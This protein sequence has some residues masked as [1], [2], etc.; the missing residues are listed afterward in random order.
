[1][2]VY[3]GVGVNLLAAL[4]G[5][6]VSVVSRRLWRQFRFRG[7]REFWAPFSGRRCSFVIGH[8]RSEVLLTADV[9]A[10]LLSGFSPTSTDLTNFLERMARHL[11][12][13]ENSGLIGLGDLEAIM[14]I[15]ARLADAGL[16]GVLSVIASDGS[17]RQTDTNLVLIGGGD[18][19]LR[20]KGLL[21]HLHCTYRMVVS[22][23][24]NAIWDSHLDD[25]YGIREIAHAETKT[26][27]RVDHGII[28]RAIAHGS[29]GQGRHVLILA[30]AQ[31][32]GTLA[33]ARAAFDN[34]DQLSS[35]SENHP[36]GFECVVKCVRQFNDEGQL[37][38]ESVETF[39]SRSVSWS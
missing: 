14:M 27:T 37:L 5:F 16:P 39:G 8:L 31:G 33:A 19:N 35:Y 17:D 23:G 28:V 18:V 7:Y 11:D 15:N 25:Y 32:I 38:K 36:R 20:A 22:E 21:E 6:L 29:R 34:L 12:S 1:M 30:G 4:I 26:V 9:A 3:I 2:D 24:K 10:D 13:Q